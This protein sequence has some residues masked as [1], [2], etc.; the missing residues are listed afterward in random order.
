MDFLAT[1]LLLAMLATAGVLA[2]GMAGFFRG[3]EFNR[4]YGNKL[5][6]ARVALQAVAVLLLLMLLLGVGR[7]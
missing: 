2:V 6:Q 4:K 1:L 3:G 7:S 5:M